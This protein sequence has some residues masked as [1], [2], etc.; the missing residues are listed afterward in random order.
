[1]YEIHDLGFGRNVLLMSIAKEAEKILNTSADVLSEL[2]LND[3]QCF[4]SIFREIKEKK[5][6]L[7]SESVK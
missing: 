5:F 4:D 2:Q 3:Q 7:E 1:M 6:K